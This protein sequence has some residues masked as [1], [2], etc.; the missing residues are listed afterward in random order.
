MSSPAHALEVDGVELTELAAVVARSSLDVVPRR[1]APCF[2]CV[3]LSRLATKNGF[4]F[5]V[6]VL[7]YLQAVHF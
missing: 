2:A 4:V 3:F 1:T 6:F 7:A 5:P